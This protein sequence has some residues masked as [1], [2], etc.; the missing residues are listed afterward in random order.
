MDWMAAA[1]A[2][3]C[4]ALAALVASLLI[5]KPRD[6]MGAYMVSMVIAFG[7]FQW[8]AKELVVPEIHA[9]QAERDVETVLQANPAFQALKRYDPPAYRALLVD[10]RTS[11]KKGTDVSQVVQ[12]VKTHVGAIARKRLPTSSNQ[13]AISFAKALLA[14]L[15]EL[16]TKDGDLCYQFLFPQKSSTGAAV[17]HTSERT[18]QAFHGAMA[19]AIRSSAEAPQAIPREADVAPTLQAVFQDL[20]KEY[21][22]GLRMLQNPSGPDVDR[23]L[24]CAMTAGLYR[25]VLDLPTDE[26]GPLLRFLVS[27]L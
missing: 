12:T 8:L 15:E 7:T 6:N 20:A 23:A 17:T 1:L 4:G 13:A 27:E 3:V 10:L 22:D 19:E 11:V 2:G 5:R 16:K 18:T 25:R 21:G 26:G 14:G 9:R 24:V